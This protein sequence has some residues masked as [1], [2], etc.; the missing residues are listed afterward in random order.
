MCMCTK[1]AV[2]YNIRNLDNEPTNRVEPSCYGLGLHD[3]NER[4]MDGP[5]FFL[6]QPSGVKQPRNL[7]ASCSGRKASLL[8]SRLFSTE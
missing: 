7:R 6:L 2:R 1:C 3:K 8:I 4:A 5:I